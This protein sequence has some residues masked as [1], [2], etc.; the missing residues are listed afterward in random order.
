[1]P[2]APFSAFLDA[3]LPPLCLLCGARIPLRR[4]GD[5]VAFC[6]DCLSDLPVLQ[7]AHCP[8]CLIETEHGERCGACLAHAPDFDYA[9]ALYRYEFPVNR[10]IH[11][12]KYQARFAP[13]RT[14]GRMLAV[15]TAD[16]PADCVLPLPLHAERL[17]ERGYNQ[18]LEIARHCACARGLPLERESL[19][20]RRATPPQSSLSLKARQRNLKGAFS[21]QRDFSGRHLLLVDDVLTTGATA[22]EAARVL[23]LHGAASVGIAVVAR[24][25]RH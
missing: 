3:L 18:A 23:K 21:C 5:D 19:Q 13:A 24:T 4:Q 15:Q 1:M 22:N 16:F 17:A 2:T 25:P 7:A 6:P 9:R 8:D 20:K 14:W 12:L 11:G 10:L